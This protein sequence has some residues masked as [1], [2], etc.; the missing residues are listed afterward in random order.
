MSDKKFKPTRF[1]AED[2]EYNELYADYAVDFIECL[3]HTKGT[4]AGK[5][6]RLLDWQEQI[7]RDLFG[8]ITGSLIP[9]ISKYQRRME[10][11]SWQQRWHYFFVAAMVNSV[12]RFMAVLPIEVRQQLYLMWLLIWYECVRH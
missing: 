4:W 10:S 12:L 3:S 7:I 5:P 2:S 8:I 11:Q 1:M 9:H 6:F